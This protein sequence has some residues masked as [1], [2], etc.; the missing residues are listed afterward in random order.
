[1]NKLSVSS[2]IIHSFALLH[3]C[4]CIFLLSMGGSDEAILTF[5]TITMVITLCYQRNMDIT[6]TVSAVILSN[7]VGYILGIA[8]AGIFSALISETLIANVIATFV[9]TEIIGWLIYFITNT[10]VKKDEKKYTSRNSV[11]LIVVLLL[12]FAIRI[13]IIRE[14]RSGSLTSMDLASISKQYFANSLAMLTFVGANIIAIRQWM[15]RKPIYSPGVLRMVLYGGALVLL[16]FL[17]SLM[18][19]FDIPFKGGADE[20]A[21]G[22]VDYFIV[23]AV[24][25][26][27]LFVIIYLIAFAKRSR[28]MAHEEQVKAQQ[29]QY[30][31]LRLKQQVNPHF[32]FNNLNILDCLVNEYKNDQ[33][34]VFIHKLASVYRY[35]LKNEDNELVTLREEMEFVEQ[36]V[37]LLKVRFPEGLAVVFGIPEDCL[38][39]K[40]VPCAVQLLIENATK[41]NV[42]T[43]EMPLHISVLCNGDQITVT[44]NLNP[45][46]S[47]SRNSTGLG[48]KYIREQY[49]ALSGKVVR[50]DKT[51]AEGD[52]P[53]TYKVTLPLI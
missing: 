38:E 18:V 13:L 6:F 12:I 3:A 41:H 16:T 20:R 21:G 37:D 17:C 27:L 1:M 36:Y 31:Y 9:T 51:E 14:G 44:N 42:A 23:G 24:I 34:S 5:L 10:F 26:I 25:E 39:K 4:A 35:M 19:A 28:T 33:A 29:A 49:V 47:A 7:I 50:I 22:I 43:S 45:K 8:G 53:A 46:A 2:I 48:L 40:L 32:L 15:R 52:K 11:S 30:R